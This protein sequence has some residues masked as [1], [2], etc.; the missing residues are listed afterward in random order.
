MYMY[1]CI[2]I[3]YFIYMRARKQDKSYVNS[4]PVFK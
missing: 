2:N 4:A 3:D 1:V